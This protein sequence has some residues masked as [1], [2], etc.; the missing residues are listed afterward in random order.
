MEKEKISQ[1]R[2]YPYESP[3]PGK[4]PLICYNDVNLSDHKDE[5]Y[6]RDFFSRVMSC[7][8]NTVMPFQ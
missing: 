7:G 3:T 8:L 5:N 2:A 4:I 6:Y 1:T